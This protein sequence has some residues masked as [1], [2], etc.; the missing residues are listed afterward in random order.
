MENNNIT[1]GM[2]DYITNI[3]IEIISTGEVITINPF[4]RDYSGIYNYIINLERI[5]YEKLIKKEQEQLDSKI[6]QVGETV[7]RLKI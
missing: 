5:E 1:I 3:T 4:D 6:K 7:K 2:S